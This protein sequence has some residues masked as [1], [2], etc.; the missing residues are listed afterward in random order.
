MPPFFSQSVDHQ[1]E[2]VTTAAA[3]EGDIRRLTHSIHSQT[4]FLQSSVSHFPLG[5]ERKKERKKHHHCRRTT[6]ESNFADPFR[7][8]VI[9][10]LVGVE[11]TEISINSAVRLKVRR[12]IPPPPLKKPAA[13]KFSFFSHVLR[14]PQNRTLDSS[15]ESK[16]KPIEVAIV[17]PRGS[18]VQNCLP[19][20]VRCLAIN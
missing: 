6:E 16:V 15:E 11:K 2:V 3:K 9:D 12:R 5:E 1:V 13:A 4:H 18:S 8:Q 7:P 14:S 17:Q 20:S 19:H 10:R